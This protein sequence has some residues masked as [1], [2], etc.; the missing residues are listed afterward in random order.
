[1]NLQEDEALEASSDDSNGIQTRNHRKLPV[2]P[3]N[4]EEVAW[5]CYDEA[6]SESQ[7]VGDFGRLQIYLPL[8]IRPRDLANNL[9]SLRE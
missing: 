5:K 9:R 8:V 1:M 2:R 6:V 3:G 4:V 7:I